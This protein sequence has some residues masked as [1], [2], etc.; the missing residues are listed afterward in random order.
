MR[1]PIDFV[2]GS[3]LGFLASTDYITLFNL[4]AHKL[5]ELYYASDRF[6]VR[7]NNELVY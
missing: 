1:H 7:L 6:H 3:R 5:H 4:T 2:F